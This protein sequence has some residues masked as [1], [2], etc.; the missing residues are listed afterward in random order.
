[1]NR[2]EA[3]VGEVVPPAHRHRRNVSIDLST[4]AD[5]RENSARRKERAGWREERGKRRRRGGEKSKTYVEV[6]P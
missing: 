3:A 6:S 4:I 5:R 1:M 2:R